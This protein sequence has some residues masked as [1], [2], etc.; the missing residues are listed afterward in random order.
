MTQI[1][2]TNFSYI[3]IQVPKNKFSAI[4]KVFLQRLALGLYYQ[5]AQKWVVAGWMAGKGM[6]LNV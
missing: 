6:T 2:S 4:L 3:S 1:T 5:V